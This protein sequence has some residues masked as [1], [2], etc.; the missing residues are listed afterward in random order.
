MKD[1]SSGARHQK[2]IIHYLVPYTLRMFAG[3]IIKFLGTIMDLLLP[4]I[5]A[6]IIDDVIPEK[7]IRRVMAWGGAM[8]LCSVFA[9]IGNVVANTMASQVARNVAR[10]LRYDLFARI[11]SLSNAQVDAYSI[12]TLISR[13]TIDTYNVQQMLGMM[14]RIGVR[15]PILLI[16]GIIVTVSLDPVLTMVLIGTLPFIISLV[17]L[18]SKKGVPLFLKAQETMDVVI[19]KVRESVAGI[20][21]IK[22]LSKDDYEKNAF[23]RAN[24]EAM[25]AEKKAGSTMAVIN[26]AMNLFLDIGLAGIVLLG[27]SR[28]NEGLTEVGKMIAFLTY[29]T[30]ILNALLTITRIMTVYTKAVASGRRIQEILNLEGEIDPFLPREERQKTGKGQKKES[31]SHVEF[32]HVSFSYTGRENHISDISFALKQGESLGIIGSTGSG[33]STLASLLMGFYP[34][35]EGEIRIN[36]RN[37]NTYEKGELREMFGAVFQNDVLF[38]DSI[39]ENIRLGRDIEYADIESAAVCAMAEGFISEKE[40]GF[41]AWLSI[42]GSNLS[43][44]QKQRLL[45]S[46]ALAGKPEILILDDSSSALDYRTEALLRKAVETH[47]K[48]TTK[49]IMA[50]RVS[51]VMSL[52]HILVL[53]DG[54]MAGYGTHEELLK[55]CPVYQEISR[56]QLGGGADERQS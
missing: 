30:I 42:H 15:A 38:A 11:C 39:V 21:V 8:A 47:Y 5:L 48:N 32:S 3:F 29:F 40:G 49:V 34:V 12:P 10:K 53:E 44:G 36:G 1:T 18:V 43:G 52:D 45:I 25:Q 22:A 50:Q 27:A 13:M 19:R 35:R 26:P 23:Y 14:Q 24:M 46:R 51:A 7:D 4:W 37:I 17:F 56:I 41:D 28:I 6:H 31:S 9:I 55:S 33:K 16:G 54:E 20:H 2:K